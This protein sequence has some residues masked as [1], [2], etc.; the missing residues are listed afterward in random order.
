VLVVLLTWFAFVVIVGQR[1]VAMLADAR[2]SLDQSGITVTAAA[3]RMGVHH[4]HLVRGLDGEKHLSL[5]RLAEVDDEFWRWFAVRIALSRG[6]PR[7]LDVQ[8]KMAKAMLRLRLDD[9]QKERA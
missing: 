6:L 7:E 9:Q 2:K 1:G 8:P 5:T 4:S 3:R